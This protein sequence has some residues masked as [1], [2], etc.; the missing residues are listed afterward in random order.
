MTHTHDRAAAAATAVD[1]HCEAHTQPHSELVFL[2]YGAY[3]SSGVYTSEAVIWGRLWG[4]LRELLL[5][6]LNALHIHVTH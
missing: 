1:A 2:R 3:T 5:T 6:L 4:I